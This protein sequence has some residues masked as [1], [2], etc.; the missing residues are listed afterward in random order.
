MQEYF[1]NRHIIF[2]RDGKRKDGKYIVNSAKDVTE[3]ITEVNAFVK[4]IM[5]K[6][7]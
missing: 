5:D 7:I 4:Q 1:I 2:H 6:I 3:L